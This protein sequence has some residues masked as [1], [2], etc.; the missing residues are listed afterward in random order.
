MIGYDDVT[1]K[2]L[3]HITLCS[4]ISDGLMVYDDETMMKYKILVITVEPPYIFEDSYHSNF[5]TGALGSVV[6]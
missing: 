2:K 3:N 4:E 6:G 1:I 5:S